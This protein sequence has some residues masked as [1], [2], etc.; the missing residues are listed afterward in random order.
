MKIFDQ[1]ARNWGYVSVLT[2]LIS[3]AMLL[4]FFVLA[5]PL[6]LVCLICAVI[7]LRTKPSSTLG[8]VGLV[9]VVGWVVYLAMWISAATDTSQTDSPDTPDGS[10]TTKS[11][12]LN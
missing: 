8:W 12:N 2:G 3:L 9:L 1:P 5:L 6:L 4:R 11:I 10:L 7:A